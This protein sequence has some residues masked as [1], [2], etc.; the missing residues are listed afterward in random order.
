MK[1]HSLIAFIRLTTIPRVCH[2]RSGLTNSCQRMMSFIAIIWIMFP[3]MVFSQGKIIAH[4]GA[5]SMAPENTIASFTKAIELGV[6]FIEVDVRPSK[7]DSIMVIHDKTLDRT[8]NGSGNVN[9]FSYSQLKELTAGYSSKFGLD[10]IDEKIPTLNEVLLLAKGK[11]KV[12]IDIKSS[13]EIPVIN[14]IGKM[15]M[16][17]HVYIMSYNVE[18]LERIKA[19]NPQI[20]TILLKNALTTVDL[21]IAKENGAFGV[22]SAYI[23]P[24]SLVKKSHELGLEY[25]TGILSDPAKAERLFKQNVDAVFTDYP[26]LMT[27]NY[28]NET[29]VSPNPFRVFVNIHFENPEDIQQVIITDCNGQIIKE[30]NQPI[31]SPLVW[32]PN[33]KFPQGLYLVYI[34]TNERIIF[35]KILF[36]H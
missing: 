13:P 28:G 35:E 19:F 17:N 3:V 18:K 22:G 5:S 27:M 31:I 6:D 11:V 15:N 14:L 16:Y 32:R 8:T 10:Y 4:R 7:E 34:I 36:N 12:C 21:A 26:Q 23:S 2:V 24:L 20:Q 33:Y 30:H 1:T 9:H 29:S 25:W